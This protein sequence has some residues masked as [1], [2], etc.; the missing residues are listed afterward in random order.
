MMAQW[1]MGVQ[2]WKWGAFGWTGFQQLII[3]GPDGGT[4]AAL[5]S[6]I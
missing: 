6:L 2:F 1:H 3:V 5:F 4:G